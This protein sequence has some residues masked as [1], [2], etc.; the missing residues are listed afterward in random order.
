VE[1]GD[2][3]SIRLDYDKPEVTNEQVDEAMW[4]IQRQEAL[5]EESTQP[6]AVGNR[7]TLDIHSEFVDGEAP[8]EIDDDALE[9]TDSDEDDAEESPHIPY[10]GEH[11]IHEHDATIDLDPEH[12]PVLPGFIDALVG[13][14]IDEDVEFE[15]IVPDEDDEDYKDIVGRKIHFHVT[16]KKV[17]NVTLPELNDAFAAR[18][19]QDEDEPLTL[20]QL[21]MRVREN[22]QAEA[23]READNQYSNQV[24]DAIVQQARIVYPDEM[25]ADRIEDLL[26]DFDQSLRQ[27]GIDLDT[28]QQVTGT[29]K[30]QLYEQHQPQ[31]EASLQHTLTLSQILVEEGIR[32]SDEDVSNEVDNTLQQFGDHAEMFREYFDTTEQRSTIANNLLY[33]RLMDRLLKIGRGL[34]IDEA[35]EAVAAEA[36]EGELA[37]SEEAAAE[38]EPAQESTTFTIETSDTNEEREISDSDESA[39]DKATISENESVD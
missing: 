32:V 36:A 31:A 18:L 28:Y 34:P 2:Y 7:V 9:D 11:F 1:L 38:A 17:E 22:L 29:T 6:V 33:Q 39:S 35:D 14:K 3:R 13:S 24:L 4:Q 16:I 21:R 26:K 27:E 25:I 5:V 8:P 10:K 37:M 19:T 23:E 30:E 12:E 20:L 15:L